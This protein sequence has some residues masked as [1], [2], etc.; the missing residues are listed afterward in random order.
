LLRESI[1][2][3]TEDEADCENYEESAEDEGFGEVQIASSIG[4]QPSF[5]SEVKLDSYTPTRVID[6]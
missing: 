4:P 1:A 3:S 6:D 2:I 5:I